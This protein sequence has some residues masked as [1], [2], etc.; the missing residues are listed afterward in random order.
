MTVSG[1]NLQSLQGDRQ[2]VEILKAFGAEVHEGKN[3]VTVYPSKLHGTEVDLAPIPDLGPV[4]ALLGCAAY[5]KIYFLQSFF[6]I[7]SPATT[8]E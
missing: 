4:V 2:I 1:L 3:S 5:G 8:T 7:H 6:I